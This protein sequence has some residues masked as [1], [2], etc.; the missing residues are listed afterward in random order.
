MASVCIVYTILPMTFTY[1]TVI[2]FS[3]KD[4][5]IKGGPQ[6]PLKF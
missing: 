4:T 6:K 1:K 3:R 2:H 5:K